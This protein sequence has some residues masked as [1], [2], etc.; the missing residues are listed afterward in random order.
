MVTACYR[1][2]LLV[3]CR[4]LLT[5]P[6]ITDL[7]LPWS[8]HSYYVSRIFFHRYLV[9]ALDTLHLSKS[10]LVIGHTCQVHLYA[11]ILPIWFEV[12]GLLFMLRDKSADKSWS[13]YCFHYLSFILSMI[14][15]FFTQNTYLP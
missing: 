12:S 3:C 1:I 7:D 10:E 4:C 5:T 8:K 2:L 9:I 6:Y 15:N 11:N 13:H 14:L